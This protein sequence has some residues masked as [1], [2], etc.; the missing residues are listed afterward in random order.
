[1]QQNKSS[2]S[3]R[4]DRVF[5][6]KVFSLKRERLTDLLDSQWRFLKMLTAVNAVTFRAKF[7]F[8]KFPLG[9]RLYYIV[10]TDKSKESQEYC[11]SALHV[12][13]SNHQ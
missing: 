8:L 1:M 2:H 11:L 6:A 12:L 5:G 10:I 4:S 9:I 7:L 13:P 3:S